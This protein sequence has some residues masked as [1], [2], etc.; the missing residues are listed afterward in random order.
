MVPLARGADIGE[1]TYLRRKDPRTTRTKTGM[2][3]DLLSGGR[4]VG[5]QSELAFLWSRY[6]DGV[7]GSGS[8]VLLSGDAGAG[9][10]R[11][12]R[13]FTT[14]VEAAGGRVLTSA[15]SGQ[16][17]ASLAPILDGLSKLGSDVA[18]LRLSSVEN[19]RAQFVALADSLAGAS[20]GQ[21]TAFILED[22]HWSDVATIDFTQFFAL[23][24]TRLPIVLVLTY[25]APEVAQDRLVH[26]AVM[27][28]LASPATWK[29]SL[30][31]LPR[32]EIIELISAAHS[33]SDAL[34]PGMVV[35]IADL[36]EGNPLLA[37]E[38][39]N[40]VIE[41]G[42]GDDIAALPN[43]FEELTV[44]R[45][46]ELDEG[47]R[48]LLRQAAVIG[49]TFSADFLARVVGVSVEAALETIARASQCGLLIE[50]PENPSGSRFR[51]ALI[52]EALY[53]QIPEPLRREIHARVL[54][55]LEKSAS[56]SVDVLAY[57][58]W[59][60]ADEQRAVE[61][62]VSA[63]DAAARIF[64]HSDAA[65][66]HERARSFLD[67]G[68]R[69][70]EVS[71]KLAQ[72]LKV[73][74]LSTRAK[75]VF[76]ELAEFAFAQG[77]IEKAADFCLDAGQQAYDAG[78]S[79]SL[80]WRLRGL[81][82]IKSKRAHPLYVEALVDVAKAYALRGNVVDAASYFSEAELL[83]PHAT[84][85]TRVDFYHYR[86]LNEAFRGKATAALA[87]CKAA[88]LAVDED[89]RAPSVILAYT[90]RALL[91]AVF[92]QPAS[93][94]ADCERAIALAR[95]SYQP[96]FEAH[97]HMIFAKVKLLAGQLAEAR[98]SLLSGL[99][100]AVGFDRGWLHFVATEV[101]ILV[102]VALGDEDLLAAYLWKDELHRAFE[103]KV[104][105]LIA[106]ICTS[107]AELYDARGAREEAA[108]VLHEG[109]A[110]VQVCG[111]T[112]WMML[113]VARLGNKHDVGAARKIL[114]AWA[115]PGE[116]VTASA[117][118]SL[119]EAL[120]ARSDSR[121]AR[122]NAADAYRRFQ[123]AGLN[124]FASRAASLVEEKD[125]SGSSDWSAGLTA[126]EAEIAELVG[127]G[128]SNRT[129]AETLHLSVRTVEAHLRSIFSKMSFESRAELAA[130]V[131]RVSRRTA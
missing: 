27:R 19:A 23:R 123:E 2:A 87:D 97:S 72:N 10:T 75:D 39:R 109:L 43:S 117:Y 114:Q 3:L 62:N 128:K 104:G 31:N 38:L 16:A 54:D 32:H 71:E 92:G 80:D 82:A 93:A 94:Q 1:T 51:H 64:A 17:Q 60:A 35:R 76:A 34:T 57:H 61:Y 99:R 103:S 29:L 55:V 9:K 95:Q 46:S 70:A 110:H 6:V 8:V 7:D 83:L 26:A 127:V 130:H 125:L 11:L 102:G 129:I 100:L 20:K 49:R 36:A 77:D 56:G 126:R 33:S 28:L 21:P 107:F 121:A 22:V 112:P 5:R 96:V 105:A 106:P 79:E 113:A 47:D 90:K 68:P 91:S 116:H 98:A 69:R 78:Q 122:A 37:E 13:E 118:L 111:E 101:T 108:N 119:F 66:F 73:S 81:E 124:W 44:R 88:I 42:S 65:E 30:P 40:H 58:A 63:G 15:C 85:T 45:V 120:A 84:S 18:A 48:E 86:G 14:R 67:A 53:T 52:R 131:A 50:D 41:S 25:R 59:A 12:M 4:F 89:T 24:A 74:G 115:R